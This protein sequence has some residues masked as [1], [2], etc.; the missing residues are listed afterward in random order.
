MIH[1]QSGSNFYYK[2]CNAQLDFTLKTIMFLFLLS[3]Y[4]TIFPSHM[5]SY[6]FPDEYFSGFLVILINGEFYK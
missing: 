6:S 4:S 3:S 5:P 1:Y 2:D